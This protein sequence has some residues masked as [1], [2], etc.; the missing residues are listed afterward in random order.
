MFTSWEK[1]FWGQQINCGVR[2]LRNVSK[3]VPFLEFYSCYQ[4]WFFQMLTRNS[5]A[6]CI[7][8]NFISIMHILNMFSYIYGVLCYQ[9]KHGILL[10]GRW[11]IIFLPQGSFIV[12]NLGGRRRLYGYYYFPAL[13]WVHLRF[14][15]VLSS[16][17]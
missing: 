12:E 6:V 5:R 11:G 9:G 16:P 15:N 14:N 13:G 1:I 7:S 8:K 2:Y 3:K 17:L 4:S 10:T